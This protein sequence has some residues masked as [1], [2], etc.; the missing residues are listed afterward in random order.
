MY[1]ISQED[2]YKQCAE[3]RKNYPPFIPY[4]V[5]PLD[6]YK[7]SQNFSIALSTQN[8]VDTDDYCVDDNNKVERYIS[9]LNTGARVLILGTG[10]GREVL[11]AKD[12]GY[13]VSSTTLG[14]RNVYFGKKYLGLVDTEIVE[15]C[16]EALPFDNFTFDLVAGFQVFEHTIAPLLFL[17]EQGRVLKNGG[18][19]FLEWPPPDHYTMNE[20]PHHQVC[21]IPGQAEALLKKA[22]F[23]NT[24]VFYDDFS[25]I[26]E[27][28]M[29]SGYHSK[30]LCV[31]GFINHSVMPGYVRR[32]WDVK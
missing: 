2:V 7:V 1:R 28:K 15:C 22:G 6:Q 16:N 25:G 8:G 17:I 10:S 3:Y 23:V 13:N 29:W 20:N 27:D 30:M 21:Y 32:Q 31:E 19:L 18:K 24:K 12:M 11:V 14:S 9:G 4:K 5:N 26:P